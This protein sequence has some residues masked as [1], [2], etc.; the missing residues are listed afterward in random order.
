MIS[1]T[2]PVLENLEPRH[3]ALPECDEE[4]VATQFINCVPMRHV[5]TCCKQIE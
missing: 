1:S 2:P 4:Q 3:F 5:F